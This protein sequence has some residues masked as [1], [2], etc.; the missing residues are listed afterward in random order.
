M[1]PDTELKNYRVIIPTIVN[2]TDKVDYIL[3]FNDKPSYYIKDDWKDID[4]I[5]STSENK[6]E[7]LLKWKK[8]ITETTNPN[9]YKIVLRI[10]KLVFKGPE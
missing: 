7:I 4:S 3:Q 2:T 9:K 10:E 5:S 6:D 1:C 8:L